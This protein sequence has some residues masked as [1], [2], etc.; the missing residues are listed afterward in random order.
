MSM[1]TRGVCNDR[2]ETDANLEELR[3]L[4]AAPRCFMFKENLV[5]S[6]FYS[7]LKSIGS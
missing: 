2:E 5:K 3:A 4:T 6:A 1:N 7:M